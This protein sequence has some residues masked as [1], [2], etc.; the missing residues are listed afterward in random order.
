MLC[1]QRRG[2]GTSNYIGSNFAVT[3]QRYYGGR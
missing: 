2:R 3:K 1:K